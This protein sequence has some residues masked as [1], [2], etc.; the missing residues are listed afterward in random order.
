MQTLE[1]SA[2]P[3]PLEPFLLN[4][5]NDLFKSQP[6]AASITVNY[7]DPGYSP[8]TGGFHPVEIRVNQGSIQYITDFCF[9][10]MGHMAEL[11][12]EIDFDFENQIFEHMGQAFSLEAG[13]ELFE[14]W[15]GNFINYIQM[16]VFDTTLAVEP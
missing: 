13:R 5:L 14:L 2:C 12:K 10:G 11:G 3:F 15:Q 1:P 9:Y 7:R 4:H 16:D 8:E 6:E